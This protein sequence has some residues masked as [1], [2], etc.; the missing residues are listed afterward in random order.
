MVEG[1]FI[2]LVGMG[3]VFVSLTIVMFL[4]VGIERLF[5][6]ES[7]EDGIMEVLEEIPLGGIP[8]EQIAGPEDNIE[9]AAVALALA[10]YL[11]ERGKELGN[12]PLVIG[13]IQYQVEVGE[14]SSLP[15]TVVV[16]GESYWA[17]VGGEGLP[18]MRRFTPIRIAPRSRLDVGRS[19]RSAYPLTQGGYWYRRGWSGRDREA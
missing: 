9:V 14:L 5:R 19:W 13:G 2:S 6:D 8:A 7:A 17:A 3:A 16:N 11:K 4:M 18:V 10:S 1:L 15:V 12:R